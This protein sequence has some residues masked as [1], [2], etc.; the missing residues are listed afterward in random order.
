MFVGWS[1]LPTVGSGPSS[2]LGSPRKHLFWDAFERPWRSY[3]QCTSTPVPWNLRGVDHLVSGW[4]K[5]LP[6]SLH[7]RS[8]LWNNLDYP[9]LHSSCLT[10]TFPHTCPRSFL[11]SMRVAI[12]GNPPTRPLAAL[13]MSVFPLLHLLEVPFF[14]FCQHPVVNWCSG[15]FA[16][17]YVKNDF[18]SPRLLWGPP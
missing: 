8:K 2:S 6:P 10:G 12:D 14:L 18:C 7:S 15:F 5:L 4:S 9:Y 16:N 17:L 1:S 3:G 11:T 13:T